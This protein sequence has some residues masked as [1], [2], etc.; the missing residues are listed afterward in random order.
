MCV[1]RRKGGQRGAWKGAKGDLSAN[2]TAIQ[3]MEG[4]VC[5]WFCTTC[6]AYA[7]RFKDLGDACKGPPA[8]GICRYWK[9]QN[10]RLVA[11]RHHRDLIAGRN[12]TRTGLPDQPPEPGRIVRLLRAQA[13]EPPNQPGT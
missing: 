13:E 6:G 9:K 10:S 1:Q 7:G 12:N 2:P 8:K 3:V 11:F 5:K 4:R